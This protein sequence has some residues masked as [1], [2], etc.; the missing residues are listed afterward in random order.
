MLASFE[1][2]KWCKTFQ[3][4]F[5]ARNTKRIL[6]VLKKPGALKIVISGPSCRFSQKI[7]FYGDVVESD[8]NIFFL[9]VQKYLVILYNTKLRVGNTVT[10]FINKTNMVINDRS[11]SIEIDWNKDLT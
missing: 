6:E 4:S 5:Y 11:E 10:I 1:S 3:T 8:N 7:P 2:K 9:T